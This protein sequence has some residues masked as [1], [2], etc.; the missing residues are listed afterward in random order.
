MRLELLAKRLAEKTN[1][2]VLEQVVLGEK[3]KSDLPDECMIWTG[4]CNN[5]GEPRVRTRRDSQGQPF[6]EVVVPKPYGVIRREGKKIQVH[7]LLAT[8]ID[9]PEFEFRMVSVCQIPGCVNPKHWKIV[10]RFQS[11]DD[12]L[13]DFDAFGEE[14]WSLEEVSELLEILLT[15]QDPRSWQDVTGAILMEDAPHDLIQEALRNLSKEHLLP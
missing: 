1:T 4:A 13:P 14:P 11:E 7:R 6:P 3:P 9:A 15:E 8:L 5:S 10:A 12:E 2:P